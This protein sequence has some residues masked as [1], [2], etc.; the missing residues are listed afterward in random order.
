MKKH[1][2]L[3][4]LFEMVDE[5][6]RAEAEVVGKAMRFGAMLWMTPDAERGELRWFAKKKDFADFLHEDF[7]IRKYVKKNFSAAGI[8]TIEIERASTKVKVIIHT[9][10]PGIII[11][12]KGADIDRL[13]DDLQDKTKKEIYIER[14]APYTAY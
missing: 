7:A 11:G 3:A 14:G 4:D 1:F 8:A 9:A 13:R 2:N 12:R 6:T 5:K 10:R